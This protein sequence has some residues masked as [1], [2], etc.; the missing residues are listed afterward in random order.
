MAKTLT[1]IMKFLD[2]LDS[3]RRRQRTRR[4]HLLLA[5]TTRPFVHSF[6]WYFRSFGRSLGT[7]RRENREKYSRKRNTSVASLLTSVEFKRSALWLP[8]SDLGNNNIPR[9][10]LQPSL[11]AEAEAEAEA[12]EEEEEEENEMKMKKKEEKEK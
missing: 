3:S 5:V 8:F 10:F 6:S 12:N 7:I 2:T 11:L 4:V 1:G 9:S